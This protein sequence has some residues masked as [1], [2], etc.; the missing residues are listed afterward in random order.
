MYGSG[1]KWA[2]RVS[3]DKERKFL[4]A[5]VNFPVRQRVLQRLGLAGRDERTALDAELRKI[6]AS[7]A[8]LQAAKAGLL[9]AY[10]QALTGTLTG[11]TKAALDE[12]ARVALETA[13]RVAAAVNGGGGCC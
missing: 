11:P 1:R 4:M 8:A 2:V 7:I 13:A 5:L 9:A 10:H 12:A 6:D 3:P